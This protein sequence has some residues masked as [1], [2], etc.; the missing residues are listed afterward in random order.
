[1]LTIKEAAV[2]SAYTGYLIG[3]FSDF[4][5]YCEG[6]LERHIWSHEFEDK[7]IWNEIHEKSKKDFLEIEVEDSL[8][9]RILN[10]TIRFCAECPSVECCPEDE[11]VL[12]R[13]EK[14]VE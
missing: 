8:R 3:D 1:M 12:F 10:E 14:I 2:I 5:E 6:I 7:S 4:H 11:C 9:N 13:I